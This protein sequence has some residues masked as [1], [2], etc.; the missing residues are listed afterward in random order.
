MQ[1]RGHAQV[2]ASA[3]DLPR[4][5]EAVFQ[6]I[7]RDDRQIVQILGDASGFHFLRGSHGICDPSSASSVLYANNILAKVESYLEYVPKLKADLEKQGFVVT[8]E[9]IN[10]KGTPR[11]PPP[12]VPLGFYADPE[13]LDDEDWRAKYIITPERYEVLIARPENLSPRE[14]LQEYSYAMVREEYKVDPGRVDHDFY[15]RFCADLNEANGTK[16]AH[17]NYLRFR[18]HRSRPSSGTWT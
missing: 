10:P 12:E 16:E 7:E 3:V 6:A 5:T 9:P 11:R 8:V 2:V 17:A 18:E 14:Q 13:L 1:S 4:S 15:L